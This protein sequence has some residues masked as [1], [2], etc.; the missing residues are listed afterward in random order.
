MIDV[1]SVALMKQS[2]KKTSEKIKEKELMYRAGR[3]VFE[4]LPVSDS[5]AVVCGKGNNGGDGYVIAQL[6]HNAGRCV[7]VYNT[8]DKTTKTAGYYLQK[9]IDSGVKVVSYE[10]QSF[11]ETVIVDCIFGVGFHGIPEGREAEAIKKINKSGSYV[12]SVDINSGL[13]ANNGLTKLCVI[14][15]LTVAVQAPKPGHYLNSAKDVIKKLTKVDIGIEIDGE[16]Y[17]LCEKD[18][19]KAVFQKRLNNS[20]KGTYGTA[21]LLGGCR[22]Y[23]GAVKLANMSLSALKCG[24]GISRLAVSESIADYVAPYLLESTLC[25]LG[26]FEPDELDK[27]FDKAASVGLGMG[28]GREDDRVKAVEYAV[29]TLEC[30]LLIDAD[31]LFALSKLDYISKGNVIITPHAAEFARLCGKT[32]DDVF[33]DPIGLSYRYAKEHNVTVLLKGASTVITDGERVFI[34]DRGTPGMATAGSGD[35][36]SG[37]ITGINSQ[38]PSDICLNAAC[39]AFIAGY[40]G[41]L[42]E[43]EKN[44][45]SMTASDTVANIHKAV[46]YIIKN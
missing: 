4:L 32:V 12:V 42:A 22:E 16:P 3:A 18:D 11:E 6:L 29:K 17:K 39:G 31:G 45:V 19:F 14:S 30:P 5:Y 21:V 27:A 1:V 10:N 36:L 37:I 44:A 35:V 2:D 9:C 38:D 13:D 7:T 15:D 46:S 24:C 41:E 28:F 33:S 23:S 20:H 26:S 40:A 34:V 43:K 25:P 8:A